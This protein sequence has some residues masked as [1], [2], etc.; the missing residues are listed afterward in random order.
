MEQESVVIE[1]WLNEESGL[2]VADITISGK[3]KFRFEANK[4]EVL[5]SKVRNFIKRNNL[6][7]IHNGL[8]V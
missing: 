5:A 1:Y 7:E 4:E 3:K 6:Q 8:P 2:L